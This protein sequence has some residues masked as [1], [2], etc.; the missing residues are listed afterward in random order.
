MADFGQ[1]TSLGDPLPPPGETPSPPRPLPSGRPPP[2]PG[3][4]KELFSVLRLR[5]PRQPDGPDSE[6]PPI[7]GNDAPYVCGLTQQLH[8]V[9]P[10][11]RDSWPWQTRNATAMTMQT[12]DLEAMGSCREGSGDQ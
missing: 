3:D 9:Q 2:P 5:R 1:S 8:L 6:D 12:A 4:R 11:G 7:R 10:L